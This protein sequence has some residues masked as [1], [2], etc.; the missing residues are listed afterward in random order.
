MPASGDIEGQTDEEE[1]L[2]LVT[3]LRAIGAPCPDQLVLGALL[4]SLLLSLAGGAGPF[5]AGQ[6]AAP[7]KNMPWP[8]P[9][10]ASWGPTWCGCAAARSSL[11]ARA[12]AP[13]PAPARYSSMRWRGTAR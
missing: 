11:P 7:P 4:I 5:S 13:A 6:H 12:R 3:G 8:L 9:Q 2:G 10:Q 1:E